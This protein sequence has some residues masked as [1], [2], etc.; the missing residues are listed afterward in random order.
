MTITSYHSYFNNNITQKGL[1]IEDSPYSF[2]TISAGTNLG[3]D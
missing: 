1:Y 2:S 3:L